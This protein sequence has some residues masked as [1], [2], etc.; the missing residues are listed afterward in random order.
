MRLFSVFK[1]AVFFAF[2]VS[3][4]TPVQEIRAEVPLDGSFVAGE[5]CS[6]FQSIRKQSNPVRLESGHSYQ[7]VAANK[8]AASHYMIIVPGATPERRWAP[9]GCGKRDGGQPVDQ[10]Q[11]TVPNPQPDDAQVKERKKASDPICPGGEL[12]AGLLR[13]QARQGRMPDADVTTVR[14]QPLHAA[15]ALAAAAKPQLLPGRAAADRRRRSRALERIA[16]RGARARDARGAQQG[17]A[18]HAIAS[19]AS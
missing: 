18:R 3:F 17:D 8:E 11:A 15:W 6:A 9:V 1:G 5:N 14:R 13:D 16:V 7:I 4:L 12:A 2:S 10:D 19:R